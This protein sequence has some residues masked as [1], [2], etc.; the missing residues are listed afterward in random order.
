MI[1]QAELQ[2]FLVTWKC[3]DTDIYC[4]SLTKL[5]LFLVAIYRHIQDIRVFMTI[6]QCQ[7]NLIGR[8]FP[9]ISMIYW[10]G[11]LSSGTLVVTVGI[12]HKR[13]ET[14]SDNLVKLNSSSLINLSMKYY[15]KSVQIRSFF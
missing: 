14:E 10:Y 12:K 8:S 11:S 13:P 1:L 2:Q 6:A 4:L 15:V 7:P 3:L 9:Y 5:L